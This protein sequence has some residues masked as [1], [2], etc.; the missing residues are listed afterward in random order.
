MID[1]MAATG[2]AAERPE[3]V[4]QARLLG[5]EAAIQQQGLGMQEVLQQI[6]NAYHAAEQLP[7]NQ[8]VATDTPPALGDLPPDTLDEPLH[9]VLPELAG[10]QGLPSDTEIDAEVLQSQLPGAAWQAQPGQSAGESDKAAWPVTGNLQVEHIQQVEQWLDEQRHLQATH[11]SLQAPKVV[12]VEEPLR[13]PDFWVHDAR[14]LAAQSGMQAAATAQ[15]AARVDATGAISD[16]RGAAPQGA[17]TLQ[18]DI[19]AHAMRSEEAALQTVTSRSGE[20]AAVTALSP[21]PQQSGAAPAAAAVPVEV[22]LQGP[23]A[24]WGEQMLQALRDQVEMQVSQRSQQATIRLD[25]P[26]LGSLNIQISHE[27]GKLSVHINA[28]QTDV[29]RLLGMLSERLRHEL[30]GQNFTE[31]SVGVGSDAEQGG[32]GRQRQASNT[33]GESIAAAREFDQQGTGASHGPASDILISV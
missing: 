30:I 21:L 8:G 19:L 3:P 18:F 12:A 29:A 23:E 24:R 33:A 1:L 32:Q 25:P 11:G 6:G 17:N 13:A 27:Q 20:T 14:R 2:G 5:G 26:E 9:S 31:V 16:G 15:P 4:R 28:A 22:R 10:D 7:A